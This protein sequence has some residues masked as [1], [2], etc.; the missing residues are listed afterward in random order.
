MLAPV[1]SLLIAV[2]GVR[3]VCF[4]LFVLAGAGFGCVA[5]VGFTCDRLLFAFRLLFGDW[6][7]LVWF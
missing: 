4:D 5:F 6:C 7:W 3:F 1:G 2:F